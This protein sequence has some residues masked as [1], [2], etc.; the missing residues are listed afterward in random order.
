MPL[1]RLGAEGIRNLQPFSLSFSPKLNIITG[2]NG[3][4][5][6]SLLEAIYLLS[7]GRSFRTTKLN[8]VIQHGD[9][10]FRVVGDV[11]CDGLNHTLS[12]RREHSKFQL[13]LDQQRQK[14]ISV[15]ARLIPVISLSSESHRLIE[16][17]PEYRRR[18]LDWAVFHV[19]RA[20]SDTWRNYHHALK[21]RNA[22]L[23]NQ[24]P[25]RSICIWD[26]P[27]IQYGDV[28]NRLRTG[29]V[30]SMTKVCSPIYTDLGGEGEIEF[31]YFHGIPS[32]VEGGLPAGLENRLALDKQRGYTSVGP[33]RGDLR[34]LK[35]GLDAKDRLSR[36]QQKILATSLLLTHAAL[37]QRRHNQ[38]A[39]IL[40]DDLP[41]ELDQRKRDLFLE[42]L[43]INEFQA[44]ITAISPDDLTPDI[45][46]SVR[47]HVEHG[48]FHTVL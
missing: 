6:T 37:Y 18:F 2:N 42:A 30:N 27:I 15:F 46:N 3:A 16:D 21:Q 4:G 5:K 44:F 22:A 19:E 20:N 9:S 7:F 17:G 39:L 32:D 8:K 34:I 28:I 48:T 13:E 40:V 36:G 11:Q 35:N 41:S 23:R 14:A 31:H 45:K 33:H 43:L 10:S 12:M 1:L 47:F 26:E 25:D 29:V 24:L 38:S